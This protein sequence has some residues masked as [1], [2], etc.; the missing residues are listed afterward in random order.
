MTFRGNVQV[1]ERLYGRQ[2]TPA[3]FHAVATILCEDQAVLEASLALAGPA[4]EDVRN[5]YDGQPA[6][7]IGEVL[8]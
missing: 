8:D 6:V 5:Y 2:D 4:F 3:P 7:L 1:T